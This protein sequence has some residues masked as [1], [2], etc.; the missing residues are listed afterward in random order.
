DPVNSRRTSRASDASRGAM[1]TVTTDRPV[2]ASWWIK[3]WPI[4]PLAPVTKT[5][6]VRIRRLLI[7]IPRMNNHDV[8]RRDFLAVM[9]AGVLAST[10]ADAAGEAAGEN[11]G[12][13]AAQ[14]NGPASGKRM[15]AY[16]ASWTS[17]PGIGQGNGGG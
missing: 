12:E 11:A 8:S 15:F 6:G 14:Q 1:S 2:A 5:E 3:P 9:G 10:V 7:R 4:S 17:G 13:S 16:V